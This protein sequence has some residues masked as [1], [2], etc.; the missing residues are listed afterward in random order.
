MV[1]EDRNRNFGEQV[2]RV[3]EKT[4]NID[5]ALSAANSKVSELEKQRN[6]LQEEVVFLQSQS[7]RTNLIFGGIPEP[8]AG[9]T[10]DTENTLR[11]FLYEKMKL[12]KEE[13]ASIKL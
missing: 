5:F 7:M 11:A 12:A 10:E 2:T 4:D 6:T 1:V 9:T 13:A 8:S 3:E